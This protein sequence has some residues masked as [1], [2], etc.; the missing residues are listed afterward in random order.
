[1]L[2]TSY[3]RD[4]NDVAGAFI[5]T[6]VDGL[7]ALGTHVDVVSPATFWHGGIA[8]G[9]GIA[10]N[11]RSAPW[12]LALVPA[13]LFAYAR[14][15]RAA[16]RDADLIHA[17]WIPSAIA[18]R[19][20]GKPYVLQVWGTDIELARRLPALAR[21][22]L[23][24]AR[25][26]LAA[27]EFLASAAEELGARHVRVVPPGVAIPTSVGEADRPP[28][29]LFAGR[30]SPE[31][32]ILEFLAATEGLPRRIVGDGP[33]RA[34][35]PEARGFV[36]PSE[37]SH[38]YARAAVVCVPSRREGY[39]FSARE[40][41]AHG[42]AVVASAVGGLADLAGP[43]VVLVPPGEIA[44]LRS[45]VTRLLE[46]DAAR[47]RLGAEARARAVAELSPEVAARRLLAVYESV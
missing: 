13:F 18:A 19:T 11:L 26:V 3:P 36:A 33:L 17:H 40:A 15:A 9:G 25:A 38:E 4:A 1:M 42:R 2:T 32:G 31:K 39:G 45:E 16:S 30:L 10:H 37:M 24:R 41:L 20:T 5:A 47:E 27:S 8:Y 12:R 14:A 44:A 35:V 21:P 46:D 22:A 23:R 7:Q 34:E 6:S 29:V 28:H 43:G